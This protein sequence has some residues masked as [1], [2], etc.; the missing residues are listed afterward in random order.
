MVS[1]QWEA[2]PLAAAA[3]RCTGPAC[4]EL[5]ENTVDLSTADGSSSSDV[6]AIV[7]VDRTRPL[8]TQSILPP[9]RGGAHRNDYRTGDP[10]ENVPVCN[11]DTNT[12]TIIREQVLWVDNAS[13]TVG[14][15]IAG[16]AP[17]NE[18]LDRLDQQPIHRQHF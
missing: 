3:P 13:N 2:G 8:M 12:G 16:H 14:D 6:V 17:Q 5:E 18:L 1:P 4:Q 9:A 11:M 7:E 10:F 15:L